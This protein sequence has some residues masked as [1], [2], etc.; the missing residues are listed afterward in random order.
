[1][2]EEEDVT[3][4][5]IVIWIHFQRVLKD[6]PLDPWLEANALIRVPRFLCFALGQAHLSGDTPLHLRRSY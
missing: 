3:N 4:Q 5:I 2:T 1:M 6:H